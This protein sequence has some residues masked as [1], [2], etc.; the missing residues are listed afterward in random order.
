M[1]TYMYIERG[2]HSRLPFIIQTYKSCNILTND[3]Q[4]C[5]HHKKI[6]NILWK[7]N[8]TK[9]NK[10]DEGKNIKYTTAYVE[11]GKYI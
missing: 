6:K 11:A 7:Y 1:Y 4:E 8:F 10:K 9:Q 5:K 3:Y 2:I